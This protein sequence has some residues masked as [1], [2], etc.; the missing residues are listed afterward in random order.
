MKSPC[1][2]TPSMDHRAGAVVLLEDG[3][4]LFAAIRG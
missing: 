2:A 4:V 3:R 1:H